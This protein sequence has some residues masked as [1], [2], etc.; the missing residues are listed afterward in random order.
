MLLHDSKRTSILA[1]PMIAT[2]AI[3]LFLLR[4]RQITYGNSPGSGIT[5]AGGELLVRISAIPH[6]AASIA[7][8]G[9]SLLL[10]IA[11][12][13]AIFAFTTVESEFRT[14]VSAIDGLGAIL[15]HAS[16]YLL[17]AL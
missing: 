7:E 9:F 4:N 11:T 10:R 5:I 13:P 17:Q 2:A 15:Q 6:A 1:Y 14:A 8:S 3:T 12:A 16:L